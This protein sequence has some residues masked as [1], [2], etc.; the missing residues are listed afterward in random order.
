MVPYKFPSMP[1]VTGAKGFGHV[2][3]VHVTRLVKVWALEVNATAKERRSCLAAT[4]PL[5]ITI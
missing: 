5:L 1:C 4:V 2:F 3:N